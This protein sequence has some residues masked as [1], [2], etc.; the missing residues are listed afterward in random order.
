MPLR[1]YTDGYILVLIR[2][3]QHNANQGEVEMDGDSN[4]A[5]K[6]YHGGCPHDCPDTCSMQFH[7]KE[8]KLLS[9]SG[10][11]EHPMK[12][13]GPKG[14]KQF[15]RISWDEALDTIVSR[16]KSI[17][18]DYGSQAILPASYLGNQGLVHGLNGGDS[19]FA[20]LGASVCERTFCG[21]G[22]CTAW[23]L[24]VGP[25]AGVDH[26]SIINKNIVLHIRIYQANCVFMF[27]FPNQ[28]INLLR[29]NTN[30]NT[31]V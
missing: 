8:G 31:E 19:F 13:V 27:R 30:C 5:V 22:S 7:V 4:S 11:P 9:V 10:N 17:I 15:E 16:W 12:R 1:S 25:T 6:T 2:K 24:T 18:A 3:N 29:V 28:D 23:L 14:A 21:E 20:R 26:E